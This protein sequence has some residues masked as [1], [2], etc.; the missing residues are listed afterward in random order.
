[1]VGLVGAGKGKRRNTE[2][3]ANAAATV[4]EGAGY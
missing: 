1:M 2:L 4:N 3:N